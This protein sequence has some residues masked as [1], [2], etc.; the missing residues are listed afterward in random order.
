[1]KTSHIALAVAAVLATAFILWNSSERREAPAEISSFEECAAAG[2]PIMESYPEQCAANGRT[3]TRDIGNEL[4]KANLIRLDSPRPNATVA[5]PIALSG[6]ARGNWYFEASFSAHLE[7]ATGKE[8]AVIPVQADG[9]WMTTEFVPFSASLAF[10]TPA[11]DTGT[12]VLRKA[13]ASGLPEH[14]D[15]LRVPVRFR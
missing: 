7:D 13:N 3:F 9:E 11:T 8:I 6:E 10:P 12:L 15:A 2:F 4:E 14:D 5:S 1:M